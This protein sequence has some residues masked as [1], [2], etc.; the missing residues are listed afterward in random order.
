MNTN[1][2]KII[3]RET[4]ETFY[5]TESTINRLG[6]RASERN[7]IIKAAKSPGG[8]TT[9]ASM[10]GTIKSIA[11]KWNQIT[12]EQEITSEIELMSDWRNHPATDAQIRYMVSLGI[13]IS[14]KSFTK[15]Q[16]SEIIDIAKKGELSSISGQNEFSG[17]Q[18]I[19]E[20]Y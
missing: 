3:N 17:T 14:E 15:G 6:E 13:N 1:N 9:Y 12:T 18:F 16:A 5:T 7:R 10:F 11:V 8:Y 20:V 4:K 19:S 2:C